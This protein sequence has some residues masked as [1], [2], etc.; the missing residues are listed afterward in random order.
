MSI[1]WAPIINVSWKRRL[2]VLSAFCLFVTIFFGEIFCVILFTSSLVSS[3][4]SEEI[5]IF[6]SI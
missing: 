6:D 2:E 5:K 1:E 3:A 4:M